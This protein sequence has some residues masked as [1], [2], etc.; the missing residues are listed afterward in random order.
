MF[1]TIATMKVKPGQE[2]ALVA[3]MDKWWTERRPKVKGAI[4]STMYRSV[5]NPSEI[6]MAVVFDNKENYMANANDPE[7]DKW[8][9]EM[10]ACFDGAP[11]W[12]DGD[13]ILQHGP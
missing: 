3:L 12:K 5:D 8:Y 9:Q 4:S 2:Q 13:I 7:Q 1:G 6:M 10:A 11:S